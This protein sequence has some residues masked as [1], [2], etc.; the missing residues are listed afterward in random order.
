MTD[1]DN[2]TAPQ[3]M[4][5]MVTEEL[6]RRTKQCHNVDMRQVRMT[7]TL[8]YITMDPPELITQRW[9]GF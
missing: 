4:I 6:E 7:Y 8:A 1:D 5:D 9:R 2:I 3:W